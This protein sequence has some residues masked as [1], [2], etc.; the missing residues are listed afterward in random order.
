MPEL[1]GRSHVWSA[2]LELRLGL[3][4][5]SGTTY[6][7]TGPTMATTTGQGTSYM[8]VTSRPPD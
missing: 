7:N 8:A 6:S 5:G 3:G 1:H 2:G 4:L